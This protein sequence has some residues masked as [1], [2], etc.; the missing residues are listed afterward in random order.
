MNRLKSLSLLAVTSAFAVAALAG[1]GG[2]NTAN[3][4][5][6]SA[7]GNQTAQGG[8]GSEPTLV[9]ATSADYKP[10]EYHVT[11]GGQ[12]KIVG[13]DIDVANAIAKQLHFK[14]KVE[15]MDFNGLIGALQAHRA[16]FVIAG[17]TPTAQREKAV[18]FSEIYYQ[19]TNEIVSKKGS[20][21]TTMASLKGKS[22][23]AQLGSIQ[24][25]A[26]KTIPGAQVIS[27]NTIPT[28]VQDV[29][30]NRADAA[31]IEGTVAK[32]YLASNPS[33]Q[34][35]PIANTGP[36]GSAIAFPKGSP[37]VSKFNTA[38]NTMKKDGE[39]DQ[40]IKKWFSG[41]NQ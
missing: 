4:S 1:C 38:I 14:M 17:M 34:A 37:W 29:L 31:I 26:A 33:L 39:L 18:D 15:D 5:N 20:P 13:F 30:T 36:N 41:S 32:G 28:V 27:L 3:T 35:N 12:D 2:G 19:A 40:L 9:M 21:Y 24:E 22:V 11:T 25:A 10:Y 16:D 6:S 23:A 8:T 7:T